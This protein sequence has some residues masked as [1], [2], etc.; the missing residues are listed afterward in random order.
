MTIDTIDGKY[1]EKGLKKEIPV[2]VFDSISSTSTMLK[3]R[4]RGGNANASLLVADS[5][6]AGRGRVGRDF[7]SPSGTGVYFSLSYESDMQTTD[8]VTTIY[9]ALATAEAIETVFGVNVGIKWVN[10]V[11]VGD[12]KCAGIL[13]E[14]VFDSDG[15][16]WIVLGIGINVYEPRQGFD[17]SVRDV[18]TSVV[19]EMRANGR[20]DIVTETI[21][22]FWAY[23]K[24]DKNEV[25]RRYID[26]SILT[27]RRVTVISGETQKEA[28]CN[29][30]TAS[31]C[32]VV[33]YDDGITEKLNA[34]EVRLR[35][36]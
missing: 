12:K 10:D 36:H 31:G 15:K 33:T 24:V 13:T 29:G 2:E 1:I 26:R 5:Q 25:M 4:I 7:W 32:L 3:E 18:A 28:I 35:I 20:N 21:N 22:R 30:I 27:G 17:P 9:A 14:R 23:G 8:D 16:S 19:G 6:T 11:Y 34:G